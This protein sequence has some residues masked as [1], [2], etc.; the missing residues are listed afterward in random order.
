MTAHDLIVLVTLLSPGLLLSVV[1]MAT[2][3]AGG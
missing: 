2:F 1:I 3:A